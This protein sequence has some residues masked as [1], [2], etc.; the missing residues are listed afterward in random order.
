MASRPVQISLDAELLQRI[1]R[2]PEAKKRGRSA[3]IRSAVEMYLRAR[4]R[5]AID[6]A[7]RRAYS[8]EA[9]AVADESAAL[10]E[11]QEWPAD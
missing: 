11:A 10:I 9:D 7:I 1:D 2:D 8:S 4:E 3:F 5:T 6:D